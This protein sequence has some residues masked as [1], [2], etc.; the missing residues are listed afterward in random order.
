MGALV[1][2]TRTFTRSPLAL[3]TLLILVSFYFVLYSSNFDRLYTE[4]P[5]AALMVLASLFFIHG[6]K[7]K[8]KLLYAVSGV[9]YGLLVL[10]IA[11][12]LYLLQLVVLEI[13]RAHV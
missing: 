9:L 7:E 1:F 4:F 2:L 13:G 11:I 12:I 6:I 5:T 8:N 10:T 3:F